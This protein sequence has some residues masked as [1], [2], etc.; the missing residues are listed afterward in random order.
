MSCKK[1]SS[2]SKI[3]RFYAI[4][5]MFGKEVNV[6]V[7]ECMKRGK[8]IEEELFQSFFIGLNCWARVCVLLHQLHQE[9]K[10]NCWVYSCWMFHLTVFSEGVLQ[11]SLFS[12]CF[13]LSV[14]SGSH[15]TRMISQT[16]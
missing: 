1:I 9:L 6:I 13:L 10:V 5:G 4:T 8:V 16:S 7:V 12:A 11:I 3:S 14:L 15:A 2:S